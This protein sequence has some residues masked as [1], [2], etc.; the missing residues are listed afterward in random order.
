MLDAPRMQAANR[1]DV[2]SAP[3]WSPAMRVRRV[4][5]EAAAQAVVPP[6]SVPRQLRAARGGLDDVDDSSSEDEDASAANPQPHAQ[7]QAHAHAQAAPL[8]PPPATRAVLKVTILAPGSRGD[9][10][11]LTNVAARLVARG[12]AVVT[13]AAHACFRGEIEAVPGVRFAAIAGDPRK[14]RGAV[15]GAAPQ[16]QNEGEEARA[17]WE[18]QLRDYERACAGCDVVCFNWF[19][20]AGLHIAEALRVPAVALWLV[21]FSRSRTMETFMMAAPKMDSLRERIA[22]GAFDART[23]MPS[24]VAQQPPKLGA[25]LAGQ[26]VWESLL[27]APFAQRLNAWRARLELPPIEGGATHFGELFRRRVPILYGFSDSVLPKPTDWPSHHLV[28]GYFL[29]EGWRGGGEG[30]CPPTD[31]ERFLETG[32]APVYLGFGSAVPGDPAGAARALLRACAVLGRR[33]VLLEGLGR[34]LCVTL[35]ELERDTSLPDACDVFICAGVVP[36]GWLLPRCSAAV[37]HGG[38]GTTGACA[39]AGIPQVVVAVEYDQFFWG[40]HAQRLGVASQLPEL[41]TAADAGKVAGA[42]RRPADPAALARA[43]EGALRKALSPA[44]ASAARRLATNVA[45]DDGAGVAAEFVA[46]YAREHLKQH[47]GVKLDDL[48]ATTE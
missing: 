21:P 14:N 18:E 8:R 24:D 2:V 3:S 43:A 23:R 46:L 45:R 13:V 41:A 9:V 27:W 28:C 4:A 32:E 47:R 22:S 44:A 19:G 39:A 37:H 15:P 11:P 40:K 33:V 48:G 17:L 42:A 25:A 10:R 30:Y 1:D 35:D 38:A 34:G 20:M 31:L 12:S 16:S 29:E 6:A 5:T 36:H 7:K 26:M